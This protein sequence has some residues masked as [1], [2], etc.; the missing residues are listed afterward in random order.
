MTDQATHQ[1]LGCGEVKD[2]SAFYLRKRKADGALVPTARCRACRAEAHRKGPSKRALRLRAVMAHTGPRTLDIPGF[3]DDDLEPLPQLYLE[4]AERNRK[5][6]ERAKKRSAKLR[7][8]GTRGGWM[9]AY[10]AE[11]AHQIAR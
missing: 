6:R 2:V 3:T 11:D 5:A 1:C 4:I 8:S 9:R 10:R 7:S